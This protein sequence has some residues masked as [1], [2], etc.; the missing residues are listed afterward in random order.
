MKQLIAYVMVFSFVYSE[1]AVARWSRSAARR[2]GENIGNTVGSSISGSAQAGKST[3]E[4]SNTSIQQ[5][6]VDNMNNSQKG[7]ATA[8][9]LAGGLAGAAAGYFGVCAGTGSFAYAA[10]IAGGI[11]L[12]MSLQSR[13]SGQSFNAPINDSWRNVCTYSTNGCNGTMPDPYAPII[14]DNAN[15]DLIK[16]ANNLA[17]S[18]GIKIDPNTGIV[19]TSDGKEINTADASS[20]SA[21]LGGDGYKKLMDEVKKSEADALRKVDQIKV[22]ADT[23]GVGGGGAEISLA[24]AGYADSESG[25]GGGAGGGLGTRN[26][27]PAQVSGLTKNFNGDPIGVSGDSIFMMMSRRYKLKSNQNSFFGA[28]LQ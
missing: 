9:I 8:Y 20:M 18:K 21:A 6:S 26:R 13:K 4:S 16:K 15:D 5:S 1:F 10:C 24:E 11:L 2:N 7:K 28:E 14:A 23:Y 12:A 19:R 17:E 3:Q 27:R 25:A 22:S